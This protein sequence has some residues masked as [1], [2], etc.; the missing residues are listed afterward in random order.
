M[1]MKEDGGCMQEGRS[2][3]GRNLTSSS[4]LGNPC[5][6]NNLNTDAGIMIM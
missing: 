6:Y 4:N 2:L 1:I 5:I 3:L